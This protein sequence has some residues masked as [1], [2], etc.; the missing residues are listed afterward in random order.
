M[1]TWVRVGAEAD[2]PPGQGKT[3]NA[4]GTEIALF[5]VGGKFFAI[6]NACCHRGGPLGE[7]DLE[8]TVV[9]CPWHGWQFETTTGVSLHDVDACVPAYPTDI[10][11]GEI[12]VELP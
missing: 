8:G 4:A 7:G 9:T 1:G 6:G 11:E 12:F 5:N 10:R 3:V 2:L